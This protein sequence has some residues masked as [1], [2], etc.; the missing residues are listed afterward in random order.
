ML[1]TNT[2]VIPILEKNL[3]KINWGILSRNSSIFTLVL[4]PVFTLNS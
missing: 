1:S 2:A 3:D 4:N